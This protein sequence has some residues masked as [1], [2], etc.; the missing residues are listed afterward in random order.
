MTDWMLVVKK[1]MTI[2]TTS[3]ETFEQYIK[4]IAGINTKF[5]AVVQARSISGAFQNGKRMDTFFYIDRD[6]LDK[7]RATKYGRNVI[8]YA[9]MSAEDKSAYSGKVLY[10]YKDEK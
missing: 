4:D 7:L 6:G 8:P 3:P 5:E 2:K 10:K 9:D 1:G